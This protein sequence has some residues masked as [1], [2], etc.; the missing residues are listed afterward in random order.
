M[1]KGETPPGYGLRVTDYGLTMMSEIPEFKG[2]L[3][4]DEPMSE[5]TSYKIGGPA[6]VFAVPEDLADLQALLKWAHAE[7]QPVFVL[8]GGN[9]LLVADKGIRGLVIKLGKGFLRVNVRGIEVTAGAAATLSKLTRTSIA[10]GLSGLE[11]LTAIPGTV[12]GAICM[13][14]GTPQGC[15]ADTLKTVT[16]L[17]T[18]GELCDV[19]VEELDLVYRGSQVRGK[20]LIII[21]AV[22]Q[23]HAEKPEA[24][25]AIVQSLRW[26]RRQSQP[27]G[28][29]SAGSVFKNPPGGFAGQ[30]LEE[31]G[32]KG[33]Q[34]GG[35]RVSGKHANFIIN[36]G[37]ATAEDVRQL[38][39]KLQELAKE[40]SGVVLEPEIESVGEW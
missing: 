20:G 31:A 33:M 18:T 24:M 37:S 40:T 28:V 38:M 3:L 12:G 21:G 30:I 8:G 35:A 26:K 29:G 19:P 14:A 36:T 7:S 1:R 34:I 27:I 5:R 17:D 25:I 23:L 15:I 4:F 39:I 2:R 16:A 13:N 11:G 9:N 10:R 6:D 22:F 32:A